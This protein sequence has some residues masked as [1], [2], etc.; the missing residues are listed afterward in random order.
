MLSVIYVSVADPLI[1]EQ[2]IAAL[3]VQARRNNQRDALTGA[4]IFNGHNFLQL[5]EGPGDK[6]DACLAVIRNDPR[7]SGMVEIRR[8]EIAERAF[9][10]W[11]MLYDPE[12]R[13]HDDD[14]ARVAARGRLDPQDALMM[15]N[16][17]ALGRRTRPAG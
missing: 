14:L 3:L 7:H 16:F 10:E 8:R 9:A 4:L 11:T 13:S 12:F 15:E 2:D 6:V 17:I 5:L 1:G